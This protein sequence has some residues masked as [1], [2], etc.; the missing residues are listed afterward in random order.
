[1]QNYTNT[2]M[3][4]VVILMFIHIDLVV[5]IYVIMRSHNIYPKDFFH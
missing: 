5:L 1:M 2:S 4:L 3:N